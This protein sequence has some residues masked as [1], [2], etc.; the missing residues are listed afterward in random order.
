MHLLRP[1]GASARSLEQKVWTT[2]WLCWHGMLRICTLLEIGL[3]MN[4]LGEAA[5]RVAETVA[6]RL[7]VKVAVLTHVSVVES[8][9]TQNDTRCRKKACAPDD[10]PC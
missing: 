9:V 8:S 1:G 6:C 10:L 3:L 7:C 2:V 4:P 5:D